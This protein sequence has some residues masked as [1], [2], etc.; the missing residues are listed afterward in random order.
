MR[1]LLTGIGWLLLL[2]TARAQDSTLTYC[3]NAEGAL[4]TGQV[5][6]WL[7]A[8]RFGTV[9][10]Q[11]AFAAAQIGLYKLAARPGNRKKLFV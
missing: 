10:I 3:I 2:G 6:F 7:H 5:P 11:G 4:S 9:P 8:N 1:Y